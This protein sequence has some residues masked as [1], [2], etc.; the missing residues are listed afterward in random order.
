V[1]VAAGEWMIYAAPHSQLGSP[2]RPLA[3]AFGW[4]IGT[5]GWIWSVKPGFGKRPPRGFAVFL[6]FFNLL[7][8][9]RRDVN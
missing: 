7:A 3:G 9:W 4:Q 2:R 1:G 8:E 5:A 6:I